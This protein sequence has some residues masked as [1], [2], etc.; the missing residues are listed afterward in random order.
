MSPRVAGD[1]VG[2]IPDTFTASGA[3]APDPAQAGR[4]LPPLLAVALRQAPRRYRMPPLPADPAAARAGGTEAALAFA[5]EARR[6]ALAQGA[7]PEAEAGVL[8]T[9]ALAALIRDALRPEAGDPSF[10][11]LVLRAREPEVD[12]YARLAAQAP[13][14]ARALRAAVAAIAHPGK[15]RLAAGEVREALAPLHPLAAAGDWSGLRHA[16]EHLPARGPDDAMPPSVRQALLA[17]PA[18]QVLERG[19][20]LLRL[21]SVQR[22]RALCEHHA[23]QAGSASAAARGRASARLGAAAEAATVQAFGE[24]A[25][26]LNRH[27]P[28]PGR[29]S[30]AQGLRLPGSFPGAAGRSKGEWDVALLHGLPDDTAADI[31]LLAEVKASAAAATTDLP[32]LLR[33]LERLAQA[34]A[35]DGYALAAR[36][37]ELRLSGRSLQA[38][39][40]PGA[41]LPPQVIYCC[42]TRAEAPPALLG[43]A[44]KAMLLAEPASVA[45]GCRLV[46]GAQPDDAA[47]RLLWEALGQAPSGRALLQQYP[48]ACAAREAMLHPQDLLAAVAAAED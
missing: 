35:D 34:R 40:P 42:A 7:T 5:L 21:E 33:G 10:Q 45:F 15:L 19:A 13:A 11:A 14:D 4:F 18:L 17:H 1:T 16:I 3:P 48:M 23:P 28:G 26:R 46:E 41:G 22:Y 37:G 6:R 47:L 9:A 36:G 38:L 39:Q 27:G 29:F 43:T 8:F 25:A 30:V 12:E 31:V 24:I 44:A 32:R 2:V 20:A